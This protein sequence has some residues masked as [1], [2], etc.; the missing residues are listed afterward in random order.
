MSFKR[1]AAVMGVTVV[2]S[3]ALITGTAPLASADAT[4]A[5]SPSGTEIVPMSAT[6]STVIGSFNYTWNGVSVKIPTGCFFTHTVKGKGK[7]ITNQFAGADCA[8]VGAFTK[9][10]NWR[11]DFAYAGTNGKT[12]KTSKGATHNS[13]KTAGT[14]LRHNAPQTLKKYGK[15]CARLYVWLYRAVV[16][17]LVDE[18]GRRP[19][20]R[21][22]GV[23]EFGRHW[24]SCQ[25][26]I[27][28]LLVKGAGHA[29]D[30]EG[31]AVRGDPA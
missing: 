15:A 8:G 19:V 12:Y 5:P 30:V 29:A 24:V 21:T 11:I 2:A 23:D 20:P 10:C 28:V 27:G 22:G 7:K 9:F 1:R 16:T 25:G 13:C 17:S 18:F 4:P 31:R 26:S 3:G 6:G 14:N